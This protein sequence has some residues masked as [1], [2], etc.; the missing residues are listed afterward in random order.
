MISKVRTFRIHA[1]FES[2]RRVRAEGG[3]RARV[4]RTTACGS[5]W[6]GSCVF[7]HASSVERLQEVGGGRKVWQVEVEESASG[8]DGPGEE[9]R[10]EYSQ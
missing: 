7:R 3:A 2:A 8:R 1:P 6:E 4:R 9:T 5:S 10:S